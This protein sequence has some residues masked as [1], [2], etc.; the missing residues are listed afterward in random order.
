MTMNENGLD[1][2]QVSAPSGESGQVITIDGKQ[3]SAEDVVRLQ[4]EAASWQKSAREVQSLKDR[5][6][7]ELRQ[8]LQVMASSQPARGPE[9]AP[10]MS[11]PVRPDS[12]EYYGPP[13]NPYMDSGISQ[14]PYGQPVIPPEVT[15]ELKEVRRQL[16][17][18][19]KAQL[20]TQTQLQQQI[21]FNQKVQQLGAD[22]RVFRQAHPEVDDNLWEQVNN[23]E[24]QRMQRDGRNTVTKEHLEESFRLIQYDQ[25]QVAI[26]EREQARVKRASASMPSTPSSPELPT[27]PRTQTE[28]DAE[29]SEDLDKALRRSQNW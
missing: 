13:D 22:S 17:L 2:G 27:V 21:E 23:R 12:S 1:S 5:Q 25:A 9:A 29:L 8:E 18:I 4:N 7:N 24:A 3:Y 14:A 10:G 26:R 6:L 15:G 20:E 11:Y 16:S 28:A 19:A